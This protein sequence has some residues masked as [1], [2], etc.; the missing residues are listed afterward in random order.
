ML[1]PEPVPEPEPEPEELP[2][3]RRHRLRDTRPE[4]LRSAS[5]ES[6]ALH[7]PLPS[8]IECYHLGL[9]CGIHSGGRSS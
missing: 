2:A 9:N 5:T 4:W 8:A 1:E 3:R 7:V 6:Q